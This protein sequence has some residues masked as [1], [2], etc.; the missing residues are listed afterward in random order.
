MIKNVV[1]SVMA[2]TIMSVAGGAF[3]GEKAPV[4]KACQ[5]QAKSTTNQAYMDCVKAKK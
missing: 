3:A 4:N 2:I 1:A 5:E